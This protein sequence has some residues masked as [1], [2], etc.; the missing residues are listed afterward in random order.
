MSAFAVGP[1]QY[2]GGRMSMSQRLTHAVAD[3]RGRVEMP[4]Y[5]VMVEAVTNGIF[6]HSFSEPVGTVQSW[7]SLTAGAPVEVN[8]RLL[9]SSELLHRD[10]A[11]G[12][13][14]VHITNDGH[15]VVCAGVARCVLVGRT[16]AALTAIKAAGPT[17]ADDLVPD[18]AAVAIMPP[19]ID[20]GLD[21]KQILSA[22]SDGRMSAGPICQLL[23][24]TVTS[25][26]ER[27]RMTVSPQPW[28]ANPLGAMQGGV[29]AAIVGQACS[30]AGQLH[31]GPG[32]QY[33][34][35]DLTV[36]YF[37]SPPVDDGAL[38]VV[39][40]P[41]RIG[42]R[43]GTVSAT[44]TGSDGVLFARATASIRYH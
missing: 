16:S 24:A 13:T 31:T 26:E 42:R 7:L 15:D 2:G 9:A 1:P 30:L 10:D 17:E 23:S 6:W 22:I 14:T 5:A 38:T 36:Y 11:H 4:A 29:M 37:R 27:T 41:D 25:S 21:G 40:A 28:M 32:Q 33:S 3:H 35:A 39:T 43:L 18:A 12:I 34:L 20:P 8:Q 19:P 44:M